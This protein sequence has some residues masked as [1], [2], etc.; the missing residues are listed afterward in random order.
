MADVPWISAHLFHRGSLDELITGAVAP[1]VEEL[2]RSGALGGFFFLRY[3][4]GGPHLRLRLRPSSPGHTVPVR[5]A[6]LERATRYLTDH[7]SPPAPASYTTE[8]YRAMAQRVAHAER[9]SYHDS[10]LHPDDTVEFIPYRPEYHAYGRRPALTAVETHFTESSAIALGLLT[11]GT[12]PAQRHAA[13]LAMLMLTLAVCE[14]NLARVASRLRAVPADHIQRLTAADPAARALQ[15][16]YRNNGHA[17]REQ[18]RDL[19]ARAGRPCQTPLSGHLAGWLHAIRTLHT[20]LTTAHAQGRFSPT[21]SLF[22]LTRLTRAVSSQSPAVAQVVLRCTHL[23]C[24]RLGIHTT[25][26]AHLASLVARTLTDL[27]QER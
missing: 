23:L 16:S 25:A 12:S 11:A 10:Q 13:A 18:A 7:P 15:D 26:E 19:W 2:T 17:L 14:P 1:L 4:E 9:L 24:N 27:N 6:L 8:A 3:W 5:A 21:D 22:P 20:Q